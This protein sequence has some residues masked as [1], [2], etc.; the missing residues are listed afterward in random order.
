MGDDRAGCDTTDGSQ[1][2]S[3]L[4]LDPSQLLLHIP[5]T[6]KRSQAIQVSK[7]PNPGAV[8]PGAAQSCSERWKARQ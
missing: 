6:S 8:I 4:N 7:L 1:L 5:P 3:V 2:E